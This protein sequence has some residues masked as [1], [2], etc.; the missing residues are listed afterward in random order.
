MGE[1]RQGQRV[2]HHIFLMPHLFI[3]FPKTGGWR[4]SQQAT[5][6]LRLACLDPIVIEQRI[7]HIDQKRQRWDRHTASSF[8]SR[9]A[10][11]VRLSPTRASYP[12]AAQPESVLAAVDL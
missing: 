2:I 6:I 4:L 9:H 12:P 8:S 3:Q 1:A 11:S 5:Q 7:I 10:L